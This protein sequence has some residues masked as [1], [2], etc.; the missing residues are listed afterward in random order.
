MQ[1]N[2][3]QWCTNTFQEQGGD[4][5]AGRGLA[6]L[7][8]WASHWEKQDA[9]FEGPSNFIQHDPLHSSGRRTSMC[10]GSLPPR[11]SCGREPSSPAGGLPRGSWL[12]G[13][14]EQE[15]RLVGPWK[16]RALFVLFAA[17]LARNEICGFTGRLSQR[18]GCQRQK[19]K[20]S[21][22]VEFYIPYLSFVVFKTML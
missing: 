16:S 3:L 2:F 17:V 21:S 9:G 11:I 18:A 1:G 14:R 15:A 8:Q 20:C 19:E 5:S 6:S 22:T 13:L 12:T 4:A 10:G 7:G